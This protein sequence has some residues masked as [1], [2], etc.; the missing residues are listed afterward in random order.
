LEETVLIVFSLLAA[1]VILVALANRL[2]IPYPI[3]LVLGGLV[4]SLIPGLPFIELNPS[5]VFILFLPPILQQSAYYTPIRDF[6]ANLRSISLLAIG[7][8]LATMIGIAIVAHA[9]IPG[10]PWAAAFVLGAIV[11][12]PDAVAASSIAQRLK[13]PRRIVTVLEGES[14][15]NDAT[16]LV[17]YR[18]AVAAVVTGVFSFWQAGAQFLISSIG[19]V[20]IGIA[21]ALL[22]TP[23][24]RRVTQDVPVFLILTFLSGYGAYLLADA[25]QCSGVLA[26]VAL[27]MFYIRVNTMTPELRI[28]GAAVWDIVVFL[29]N[30]LIFILIGLQMRS[31]MEQLSGRSLITL[32]WYAFVVCLTAILIRIAW[33]FP[34]TYLP[35][36]PARVRT[37][38]PFPP[39]QHATIVAW[40][41][42]RGVVSLASALALPLVLANGQAFPQRDLIIFLTSSVILVT[43]VFQGLTLPLLIRW[44]KVEDDGGSEREENKAR[45]IAAQAAQARLQELASEYGMKAEVLERINRRYENRVRLFSGRY[46]DNQDEAIEKHF[47]GFGK[48]ELDLLETEQAAL[49]KLRNDEV[50]NDEVLRTVQRDLD[51]EWLRLQDN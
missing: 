16:A 37:R 9:L 40:T 38:D 28:Q 22:L 39:W 24:F 2:R 8:V 20:A 15:L 35:R 48:L 43:L 12:P 27:G 50:I 17:S 14:M 41:V 3:L 44:L 25:L 10:M 30:G 4:I 32:C 19:G 5:L 49:I 7:L 1:M 51:L 45:L 18:V 6:R 26:V 29:L 31:V 42:M 23:I 47:T 46:H 21:V 33:V 36:L 34:G 13:L 11:A